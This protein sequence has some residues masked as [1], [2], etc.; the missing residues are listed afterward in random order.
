M[1]GQ[2][3]LECPPQAGLFMIAVD[4]HELK[5]KQGGA[6][7][8]IIDPAQDFEV[9][10]TLLAFG[11][12]PALADAGLGISIP[13][14]ITYFFESF[15]PGSEDTVG[16]VTGN[17]NAGGQPSATCTGVNGTAIEFSDTSPTSTTFTVTGGTL[18]PGQTIK[19]TAVVDFAGGFWGTA[20][21]F[22]EGPIIKT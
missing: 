11:L 9:S 2:P 19:I 22:V 3:Q 15:G 18:L 6:D 17:V 12:G 4:M 16:N 1:P 20:T 14:T 5:V 10:A 7:V 21:A 13:Y 8:T